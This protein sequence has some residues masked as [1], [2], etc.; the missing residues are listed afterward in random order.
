MKTY[1]L[2]KILGILVFLHFSGLSSAQSVTIDPISATGIID[3]KSTTKGIIPPRM[4]LAERNLLTPT[5][6]LQVYCTNCSP[7]GPYTYNGAAWLAMFQTTVVSPITYTIGQAAQ[8]GIVFWLD[9]TAQH[10]L[11]VSS[12]DVSAAIVWYNGFT[13]TK[14]IRNGYYG[15][16]FNT[17]QIINSIGYGNYAASEAD[18]CTTGVPYGDWYLPA[19]SELYA[20]Y[21]SG[22]LAL[23]GKYWSS[24]E[25]SVATGLIADRAYAMNSSGIFTNDLKNTLNKV[26]AIRKF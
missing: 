24:T 6:G 18:K 12:T 3:A 20:L 21:N 19:Y 11:V 14:A 9:E 15:G 1:Y 4:T 17:D 2:S 10:G 13:N 25:V 16:I 7:A 5:A 22:V 26:R 8:G 23:S